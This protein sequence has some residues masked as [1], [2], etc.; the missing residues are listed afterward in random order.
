V[1]RVGGESVVA[2]G[3][4][5]PAKIFAAI[6]ERG[7]HEDQLGAQLAAGVGVASGVAHGATRLHSSSIPHSRVEGFS[8]NS[9]S[10]WRR[11]M[12]PDRRRN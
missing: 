9:R 7:R 10:T 3:E 6:R 4:M 2:F 8:M 5:S 12:A 1:F 11:R